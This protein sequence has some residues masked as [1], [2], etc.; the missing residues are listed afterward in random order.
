MMLNF[1][2]DIQNRTEKIF[3]NRAFLYGDSVFETIKVVKNKILFWEEHYL[4][5]M[6]S[7]RIL[8]IEIPNTFTPEY[9]EDQIKKTNFSISKLFSGRVRL[10]IFR[11]GGGFYT[12]KSNE[13]CFVIKSFENDKI[14]FETEFKEYKVDIYKDYFI[15]SNLL[16]NLKTNNRLINVLGGIY[17]KN[18]GLD[19]CILLNDQKLVAEF[20]NGN[21]FIVKENIV[22]TPPLGSGCLSGVMRNKIIESITGIPLTEVKEENFSAYEIISSQEIWVS[23]CISG[24]I[25]VTDYRNKQFGN[26]LARKVSDL[27]NN[28]ILSI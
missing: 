13:S 15:Q 23:N 18:N 17:A 10:T 7:M 19:N 12:P 27:F 11:D 22:L 3:L 21:I 2:G 16:S 25:P 6:S 28:E 8:K 26:S 14:L 20:L 4:R 9:L 1:N 24:I 5:L